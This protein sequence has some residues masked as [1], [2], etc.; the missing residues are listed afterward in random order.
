VSAP[1]GTSSW[2][3]VPRTLARMFICPHCQQATIS[4]WRKLGASDIAPAKCGNC[5]GLS[6]VSN[7][8]HF[9]GVLVLEMLFWG[10]VIAAIVAKSWSALLILPAG[11]FLWT[12]LVGSAFSL[13]PI[14]GA[15]VRRARRKNALIFAGGLAATLLLFGATAHACQRDKHGVFE[16]LRCAS[17]AFAAADRELNREYQELLAS[18]EG[19]QRRLLVR[20]QRAWLAYIKQDIEFIYAMQ[21]EGVEGRLVAVNFNETQSRMRSKA[22]AQWKRR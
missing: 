14:G 6:Y 15:E 13:R 10:S 9:T 16:E 17:D 3:P 8:A 19:D 1:F 21:G 20:S 11:L 5:T 7:W 22:L 2:A 4:G 18:L 12:C